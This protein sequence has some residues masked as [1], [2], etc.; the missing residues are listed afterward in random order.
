MDSA[1]KAIEIKH[2][3]HNC[4]QAVLLAYADKL[5]LPEDT[6]NRL[7]A[8]FGLGMGNMEGQCGAL[9]AAQMVISLIGNQHT[10]AKA[11]QKA[12]T[13]KAGSSI[14][15]ELKGVGTNR[16]PLCSC[17][18]CVRIAVEIVENAIK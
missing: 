8:P 11:I 5:A 18:N 7:G 10:N 3:G 13:D 15:K 4:C 9:C 6:L 17:E 14:C 2:N 12:F 16:P 1:D